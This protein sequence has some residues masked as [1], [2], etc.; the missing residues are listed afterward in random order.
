MARPLLAPL[1]ALLLGAAPALAAIGVPKAQLWPRWQRH[2]TRASVEL[3][4]RGWAAFLNRY[5]SVGADGVARIAYGRVT[6]SDRAAL[7][8]WLAAQQRVD[9]DRLTR[10][11]QMAFW[12]NL[13][14]A[15]T[16]DVV[17]GAYPVSSIRK[18]EGGLLGLGPWG[19]PLLKV[20]GEPL[21]LNDIEHRILRP[22]W[23]DVRIHYAVNCASVGCPDLAAQPYEAARLE[24]Q[25][26]SAARAYINSP[27]GFAR[28]NGRLVASSI[29]DWYRVD[30]GSDAAVLDHACRYATPATARLL[31]DARAIDRHRYDW[32]L[33]DAR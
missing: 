22:I 18:V 20:D 4:T 11:Q 15:A 6:Q 29:F 2:A 28:I 13:Y 30:W 1:L 21:S 14:N 17:L 8:A 12:I 24:A 33:N 27:R 10:P 5:R 7:S 9:V 16:V 3:D 31:G 26:D 25:L 19:K 32:S 23:K